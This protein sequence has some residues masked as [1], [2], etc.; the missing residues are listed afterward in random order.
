MIQHIVKSILTRSIKEV[1]MGISW[2]VV[3]QVHLILKL[4]KP[5]IQ[6]ILKL[7]ARLI[8]I[9]STIWITILDSPTILQTWMI[10]FIL[11]IISTTLALQ[12]LSPDL[13]M[14]TLIISFTGQFQKKKN[15]MFIL[16]CP[17]IYW[18]LLYSV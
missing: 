17:C 2:Q 14:R 15:S 1:S 10:S 11:S 9:K 7:L 13:L 6:P 12:P 16:A 4:M 3:I 18:L 8:L 5:I